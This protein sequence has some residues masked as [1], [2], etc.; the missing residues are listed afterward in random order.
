MVCIILLCVCVCRF[1]LG[2]VHEQLKMNPP[3]A[4]DIGSDEEDSDANATAAGVDDIPLR[5][6]V[7][8]TEP[9]YRF[10][11]MQELS[12]HEQSFFFSFS[13]FFIIEMIQEWFIRMS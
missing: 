12:L 1:G 8:L 7:D 11:R 13:L 3:P 10:G 5:Y 9:V 4:A 6:P 2:K